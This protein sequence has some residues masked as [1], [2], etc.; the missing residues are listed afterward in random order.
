ML[1]M[2]PK[3]TV[4]AAAAVPVMLTYSLLFHRKIRSMFTECDEN[5]GRLSSIVQENLTGVR[6]VR[7]FGRES[8]EQLRFE[9]QNK[10][11]ASLWM[12]LCRLFSTY[13]CTADLISGIQIMLVI[14]IG[15]KMCIDGEMT[16]GSYL[17]FITYNQ[18]LIWPVRQ[19]GRTISEL[20]KATVSVDR[21][22]EIMS[23]ETEKDRVNAVK[24][25]MT[26][27][28]AFDDVSF[29]YDE[30]G[31]EI[32]SHVSFTVPAGS[33]VGILGGTG[34]GKSTLMHLLNRLYELPEGCGKIT[35][36]SVD[37]ADI[38]AG[39]LRENI[40]MVLQEPFLFS[41]SIA[42]NIGISK[43]AP[44]ERDI[45]AAAKTACLHDTVESFSSGYDTFVGERGVT[46]SGGQKQRAA[47]ARMLMQQTPIM[48][49]DDSLSAVD[50]ETDAKIRK[51]LTENLGS[52]SVILISHRITT[53]M[54]ADKIIVLENGTVA[55]SGTHSQLLE[56][57]GIY[58]RI[59]DIQQGT[60]ET[61]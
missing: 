60:E 2:N 38:D 50:T 9:K 1:A 49:F 61:A 5:E 36:G 7:A 52:S 28:I 43:E 54:H 27:D 35:I 15:A 4:I 33:T 23:A 19:L 12:R 45:R 37:I 17:A 41:R 32:L 48:V 59:Y 26:R 24:P 39:Y 10:H 53:L 46:L 11:Y 51:A 34:S 14:I 22:E 21:I 18:N 20:S 6:V 56:K 16:E 31:A 30:D 55:E 40:G 3:L 29:S 42:E 44:D 8:F 13:W 25:D 57:D 47:I 58:K